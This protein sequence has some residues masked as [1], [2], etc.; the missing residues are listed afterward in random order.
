[1]GALAKPI[2]ALV[3]TSHQEEREIIGTLLENSGY[4]VREVGGVQPALDLR[5]S[6]GLDVGMC[7]AE[8]ADQDAAECAEFARDI[9]RDYT[10]VK[11]VISGSYDRHELAASQR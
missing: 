8:F 11:V 1:M 3:L 7:F 4:E 5:A 10:W 2:L 9:A 6:V